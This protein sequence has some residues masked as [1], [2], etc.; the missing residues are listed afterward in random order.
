[1][2]SAPAFQRDLKQV[3][4]QHA[5]EGQAALIRGDVDAWAGLDQMMASAEVEEGAQLFY[6]NAAANTWG[7]LNVREEFAKQ[8]PDLVKRVSRAPRKHRNIRSVITTR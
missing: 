6:R 4:L 3:L 7:I 5:D 1:M 8:N 2:R